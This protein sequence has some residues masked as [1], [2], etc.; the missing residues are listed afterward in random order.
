[1]ADPRYVKLAQVLTHYSLAVKPGEKVMIN[2]PSIAMPLIKEVYREVLQLGAYPTP[3]IRARELDL[4]FYQHASDDQLTHISEMQKFEVEYFDAELYIMAEENTRALASVDPKRMAVS[5]AAR[6]GLNKRHDQRSASGEMRWSLTL[7]PTN[8][9]AQDA[10]MSLEAYEDFVFQAAMLN[11][12]DPVAAWRR[13]HDEQQR[14]VDYL[15]QHDEIHVQAEGTDIRYRVGGR[16]WLN[17]DGRVNF[18]D[19]EVFSAP[20]E[21]SVNG[22]VTFS[23]PAIYNGTEV[24]GIRLTFRDGVVIEAQAEKGEAFLHA[25]LDTDEGSRRLGE[26]AFGTNYA[27]THFSREILFDEKIGGTMHMALGQSYS[28]CGGKN[29]SGLHW[30]M[31]SDLGKAQVYADGE[32]FYENG[33]FVI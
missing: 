18:P 26:V 25:M 14:I 5:S 23:Y 1:M 32:L 9:Y 8:A 22:T 16:K 13:V 19:G 33:K 24:E 20:I 3:R 21:D 7:Y 27:I 15:M 17:A 11:E 28:E 30:D 4:L 29:E 31:I 2:A 12:A 10:G 6:S